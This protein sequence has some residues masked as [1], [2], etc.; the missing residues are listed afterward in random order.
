M[1]AFSSYIT[2]KLPPP[3]ST[4]GYEQHVCYAV[5]VRGGWCRGGGGK[6][7]EPCRRTRPRIT[8]RISLP[9]R[10]L[11]DSP[12]SYFTTFILHTARLFFASL[13]PL[14]YRGRNEAFEIFGTGQTRRPEDKSYTAADELQRPFVSLFFV[15]RGDLL[16]LS[17]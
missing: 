14:F 11:Y 5:V 8:R 6:G 3:P 17:L 1:T 4:G 10:E 16:I 9:P 2:G 12:A 7:Q 13:L 15:T